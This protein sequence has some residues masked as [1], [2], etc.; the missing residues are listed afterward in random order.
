MG[1]RGATSK[2]RIEGLA[3]GRPFCVIACL[4]HSPCDCPMRRRLATAAQLRDIIELRI[5]SSKAMGGRCRLCGAPNPLP[6]LEPNEYGCNWTVM[7]PSNMIPGCQ[8]F[9][10]GIVSDVMREYNLRD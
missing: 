3:V 4:R 1:C 2:K 7:P 8:E 5:R 10:D 9:V 6:L